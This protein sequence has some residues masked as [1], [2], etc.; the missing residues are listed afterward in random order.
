M[1]KFATKAAATRS[2]E[3]RRKISEGSRV[4]HDANIKAAHDKVRR[5]ML[6]IQQE[7]VGNSGVYPHN[8]GVISQAE[9]AR[10]ASMHPVTLH[11]PYYKELVREIQ[12]WLVNV[13]SGAIV[14][15][16]R[17]RSA[18]TSRLKEH[19]ELRIS[20]QESLRISE[21]D[22]DISETKVEELEKRCQSLEED[23]MKLRNQLAQ[24]AHF[25]LVKRISPK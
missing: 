22:L 13:K 2:S 24:V 19:E 4:F 10:R 5:V 17:V 25:K 8:K 9:L 20:L 6:L 7:M 3:T 14:G 16:K 15:H 1:T 18:L 21:I 11:K 23:N 12:E